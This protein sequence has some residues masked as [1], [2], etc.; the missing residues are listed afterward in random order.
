M[1]SLPVIIIGVNPFG[2]EVAHIFE[3][4]SVNALEK[5][6]LDIIDFPDEAKQRAERGKIRVQQNFGVDSMLMGTEKVYSQVL[7][8]N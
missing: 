7:G 6:M 3:T 2:L 1:T 4:S 8:K 5:A